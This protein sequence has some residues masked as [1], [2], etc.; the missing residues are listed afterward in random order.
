MRRALSTGSIAVTATEAPSD[1]L[2]LASRRRFNDRCG[3][4]RVVHIVDMEYI[5]A[6]SSSSTA[7]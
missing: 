4:K 7:V 3:S 2:N 1:V 6:D 5:V